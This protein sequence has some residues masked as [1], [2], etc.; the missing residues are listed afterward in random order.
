MDAPT[1]KPTL[2]VI[3]GPNGAGKTTFAREFLPFFANCKQFVNAD[4][5]AQGLA[6]FAP[7]TV[8]LRAGRLMLDEIKRLSGAG[9]D[10][11]IETTLSG[12]FYASWFRSLRE[13]GYAVSL[14]FLWLPTVEMALARVAERVVH[15][16]HDVPEADVRRRYQRGTHNLFQVYRPILDSWVLLDNTARSPRTIAYE[17]KGRLIVIDAEVYARVSKR[18]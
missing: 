3:A 8:A 18:D 15:G 4:L 12:K 2:Y 1:A 17:E 14:F 6:P 13:E 10:F 9:V 16:G 7:E 11:A 5:I